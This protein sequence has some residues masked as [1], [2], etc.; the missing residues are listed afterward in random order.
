MTKSEYDEW[1]EYL[2]KSVAK[3]RVEIKKYSNEELMDCYERLNY[4][5]NYMLIKDPLD[6]FVTW[7]QGTVEATGKEILLR[8]K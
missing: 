5:L 4:K 2:N 1:K 7:Y 3:H 6:P 8:M